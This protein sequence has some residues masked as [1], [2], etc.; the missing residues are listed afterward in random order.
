[1]SIYIY[2]SLYLYLYIERE[3][4]RKPI[5]MYR[6]PYKTPSELRPSACLIGTYMPHICADQTDRG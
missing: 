4:E 3:K 6:K 5:R 1:M 2:N